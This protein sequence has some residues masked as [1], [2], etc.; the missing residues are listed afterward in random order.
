MSL[1]DSTFWEVFLASLSPEIWK[2][3]WG[4]VGETLYMTAI[5][6]VIMLVFG[7]VIGILLDITNPN[8]LIP[9]KVSYTLSGW[10]I[11]CLRSLPQMIMIILMIPVARLI[12][13]KSYGTNA[14]II[15]IA[16]S[17]IPM[18][19]RIVESSLLEIDKGKIE[20]AQ[21]MGSK[22]ISIVFKVLLP[23]TLPSLI[24]GFTVSVITVLSMTA[25]AGMFGAGG[26]G[27]IAVRYG[28]QRF[29]HD[30]LFACVYIL[31]I[32]VQLIQGIGNLVSKRIL[33]TRNL[34]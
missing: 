25:L 15:A 24:R 5:S 3:L 23:E 32:L 7:I 12:F 17:C 11:N 2:D 31:I 26:I 22:N 28:Y 34:V 4:P 9:L 30:R 27:D 13:G 10:M 16:A 21:A 6:S 8:G 20:A 33:K 29:Q 1:L 14:C 18:Y 19:A